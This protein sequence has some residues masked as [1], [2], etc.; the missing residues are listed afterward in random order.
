MFKFIDLWCYEAVRLREQTPPSLDDQQA[1]QVA[2]DA[3]NNLAKRLVVRAR[4]LAGASSLTAACQELLSL[5]R[6]SVLLAMGL[7]LLTGISAALA[8]LGDTS[9]P[10]NV[11]WALVSLLL[12]PT[13]MLFIWF[14]MFVVTSDSGGWFGRLWQ[15]T[16][17]RLLRDG[18]RAMVWRAW[19]QLVQQARS[20]RWWLALLT[21]T[22]WF[23]VLFGMV[24]GMFTAFSLRHYTFVWQTTWLSDGVFV[25]LAQSIGALP[26]K[27]GFTVPNAQT[28]QASGNVALDE[29]S[30]RL[31]WANWLMGAVVVFGLLPRLIAMVTSALALRYRYRALS[32]TL[33]DAY[34]LSLGHKFDRLTMRSQVDGP[35]G[36]Q[37]TWPQISGIAPEDALSDAAVVALETRLGENL[38]EQFGVHATV[39]PPLDD[40][41]SRKQAQER[42]LELKPRRLLVVLDARQTPDRGLVRTLLALGSHAVDT[43]VLLQQVDD[44]RARLSAWRARLADIGLPTDLGRSDDLVAWLRGR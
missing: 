27:L 9:Q 36:A 11:I 25:Q 8:S 16:I 1:N 2:L 44:E 28:I 38:H 26:G 6:V 19:L 10:V 31:A 13:V 22:I 18:P 15:F 33:N 3:S 40:R 29:P 7:G 42:L 5:M 20:E 14:A 23:S 41:A 32:M 17:G 12:L 34:A 30:A 4:S 39:L 37:E 21:H 35:P 43:K 24:L